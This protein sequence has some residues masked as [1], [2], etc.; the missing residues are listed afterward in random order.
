MI[1]CSCAAS[2]ARAICFAIGKASACGNG[3]ER[4][5]LRERRALDQLH[6]ESAMVAVALLEAVNLR[7]VGMIE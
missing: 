6:H 7:D 4:D 5:P 3:A 1:P 2:S